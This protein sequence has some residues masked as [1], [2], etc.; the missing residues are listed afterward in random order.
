MLAAMAAGLRKCSHNS[1]SQ[2][3]LQSALPSLQPAVLH[4]VY[5]GSTTGEHH[6]L[7]LHYTAEGAVYPKIKVYAQPCRLCNI[8][9][10]S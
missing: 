4:K 5:C 6:P 2:L 10:D 7:T 9:R 3:E 8:L 1:S